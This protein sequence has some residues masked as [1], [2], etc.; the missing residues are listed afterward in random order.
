MERT[1]RFYKI[2]KRLSKSR[3]SPSRTFLDELEISRPTFYRDI[4][5]LKDR[6]NAPIQYDPVSRGYRFD[7]GAERFE[8][9]GIWFTAREA[10]ALLAFEHLLTEVQPGLLKKI[11][12]PLHQR[13]ERLFNKGDASLPEVN[14][15]IRILTLGKRVVE[16]NYFELIS[17][18][19]LT[20]KRLAIR[21]H[22]R[23]RDETTQREVSPQRLVHYRDNWYLDSYDHMRSDLRT[24][25]LD[26]VEQVRVLEKAAR[27]VS[28]ERLDRELGSGFGIFAGSKTRIARLRFTSFRGRW[29][30]KEQ[31]HPQQSGEWQDDGSY[32]LEIPYTDDREL[33][34]DILKYGADVEVL[35]PKNLRARVRDVLREAGQNY[36]K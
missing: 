13:L 30:A 6:F 10:H 3:S 4:E 34:M 36:Q 20:R 22:N 33:L 26:A 21:Y 14:R 23:E 27:D 1:E 35:A 5:Y 16:P 7:P 24:F 8:L 19:V 32:V 2:C 29:I 11:L 25:S 17:H 12:R 31:W 15:R 28:E 9:P 18:A